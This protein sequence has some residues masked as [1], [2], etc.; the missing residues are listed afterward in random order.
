MSS[1][2]AFAKLEMNASFAIHVYVCIGNLP[3]F[4]QS[5]GKLS[6]KQIEN[7]E[8]Q[9]KERKLRKRERSVVVRWVTG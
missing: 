6:F 1:A 4:T 3:I 7:I 2:I 9:A 8:P 5:S